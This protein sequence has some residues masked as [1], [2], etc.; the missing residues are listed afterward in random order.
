MG[1][2]RV[3]Y[4]FLMGKPVGKRTL[5]RPNL[6]WEVNIQMVL[7]QIIWEGVNWIY[8]ALNIEE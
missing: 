4:R 8:V 3:A 5:G 2:K 1:D 7:H 6:I